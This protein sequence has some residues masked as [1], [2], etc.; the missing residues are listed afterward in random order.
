MEYHKWNITFV[1]RKVLLFDKQNLYTF[2][3][4]I[5]KYWFTRKSPYIETI[6]ELHTECYGKNVQIR[7]QR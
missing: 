7:S 1:I 5:E 2:F 3:I 6:V 4:L